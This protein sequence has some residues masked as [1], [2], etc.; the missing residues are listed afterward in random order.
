MITVPFAISLRRN[1]HLSHCILESFVDGHVVDLVPV[2]VSLAPPIPQVSRVLSE[3]SDQNYLLSPLAPLHSYVSLL[4]SLPQ[5]KVSNYIPLSSSPYFCLE[6]F[7]DYCH[8]MRLEL[9]PSLLQ[10]LMEAFHHIVFMDRC[11]N[12]LYLLHHYD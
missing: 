5:T 11:W 3:P 12:V 7:H 4:V 1:F 9:A 10:L 6:V 2:P 8:L